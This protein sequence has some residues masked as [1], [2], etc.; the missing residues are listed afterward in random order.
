[1]KWLSTFLLCIPDCCDEKERAGS[2]RRIF[3]LMIHSEG[4]ETSLKILAVCQSL[5]PLAGSEPREGP[6]RTADASGLSR[7]DAGIGPPHP[8]TALN[9]AGSACAQQWQAG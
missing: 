4:D 6:Q 7:C 8:P 3:A 9:R 2:G 1:M 5:L